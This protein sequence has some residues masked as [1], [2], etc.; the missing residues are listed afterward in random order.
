LRIFARCFLVLVFGMGLVSFVCH[1]WFYFTGYDFKGPNPFYM[2][3]SLWPFHIIFVALAIEAA[4]AWLAGVGARRRDKRWK[5]V[6]NFTGHGILATAL[7]L[8]VYGVFALKDA[9]Y[10][11]LTTRPNAITDYL[12]SHDAIALGGPYRGTVATF[13]GTH[14]RHAVS[15]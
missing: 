5:D 14:E 13:I 15:M 10:P 6:V 2:V 1:F 7:V 11:D 12:T 9:F 8:P 4:L 3:N